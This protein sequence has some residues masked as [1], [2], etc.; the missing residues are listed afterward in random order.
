MLSWLGPG[1]FT[2]DGEVW[3]HSREMLKPVFR[4]TAIKDMGRLERHFGRLLEEVEREGGV[5]DLQGHFIR[6]VSLI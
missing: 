3:R 4:R 2:S 5:V 1:A 6:M